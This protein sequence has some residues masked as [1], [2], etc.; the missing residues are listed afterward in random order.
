MQEEQ[1]WRGTKTNQR[2]IHGRSDGSLKKG[3]W[4]ELEMWTKNLTGTSTGWQLYH[5]T[6]YKLCKDAQVQ[7]VISPRPRLPRSWKLLLA[8]WLHETVP[9]HLSAKIPTS[10]HK[11]PFY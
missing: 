5:P 3:K 10:G 7:E 11:A 1:R 6:P 2:A 4:L 8:L 9:H